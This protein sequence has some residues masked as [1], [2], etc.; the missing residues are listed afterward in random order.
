MP[1][2]F[3]LIIT[4]IR[5]ARDKIADRH[6]LIYD[7]EDP[8]VEDNI[9]PELS[10]AFSISSSSSASRFSFSYYSLEVVIYQLNLVFVYLFRSPLIGDLLNPVSFFR[11]RQLKVL[12]KKKE[13][14][15]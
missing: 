15:F 4:W 6:P 9:T 7:F 2:S 10:A 5:F 11:S 12:R 3:P 14:S 8:G 13:T 1:P